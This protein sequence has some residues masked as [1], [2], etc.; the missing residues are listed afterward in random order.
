MTG[1]PCLLRAAA[2]PGLLALDGRLAPTSLGR[3]ATDLLE[4]WNPQ[5]RGEGGAER[6]SGSLGKATCCWRWVK[7]RIVSRLAPAACLNPATMHPRAK[8]VRGLAMAL[9]QDCTAPHIEKEG[10]KAVKRSEEECTEVSRC[11]PC[12]PRRVKGPRGTG[13]SRLETRELFDCNLAIWFLRQ[14]TPHLASP[15]SPGT[16][17]SPPIAEP[18]L[19]MNGGVQQLACVEKMPPSLLPDLPPCL[20]PLLH[21]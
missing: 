1:R 17:E 7:A 19:S 15:A 14:P 3:S 21:F 8:W 10:E 18:Q 5:R 13:R 16:S 2:M 9:V 4:Y 12:K 20:V 6:E 11:A